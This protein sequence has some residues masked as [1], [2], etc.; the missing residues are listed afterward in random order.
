MTCKRIAALLA[1]VL[2]SVVLAVFLSACSGPSS[3]G[4]DQVN[5]SGEETTVITGEP[6]AFNA[7]SIIEM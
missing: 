6:A 3:H 2:T 1:A 7:A 4:H 5:T